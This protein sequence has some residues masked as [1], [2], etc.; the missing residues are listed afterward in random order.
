MPN[1]SVHLAA[2][3]QFL[4]VIGTMWSVRD[5]DAFYVAKAVYEQILGNGASRATASDAALALHR[6]VCR[7]RDEVKVPLA[8][9]VPFIHFVF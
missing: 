8:Q 2:G 1:E 3:L 6:A 4:G 9:W 5:K 7:L